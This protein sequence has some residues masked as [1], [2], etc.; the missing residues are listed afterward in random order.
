MD[1]IAVQEGKVT[2][3]LDWKSDVAPNATDIAL[4]TRQLGDYLKLTNVARGALVYMTLEKFRWVDRA[5]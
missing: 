4:H 3:V 1:A 5:A 2:A